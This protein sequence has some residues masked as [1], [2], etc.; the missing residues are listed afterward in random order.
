MQAQA[1]MDQQKHQANM[2]AI[3][4]KTQATMISADAEI[5]KAEMDMQHSTVKHNQ[6]MQAAMM[7]PQPQGPIQ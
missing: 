4:A 1:Q 2:Q 7:P 3:G 5:K 6:N